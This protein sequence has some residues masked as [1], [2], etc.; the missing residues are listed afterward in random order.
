MIAPGTRLIK[1]LM[2]QVLRVVAGTVV[3]VGIVVL[4]APLPAAAGLMLTFPALN[5]L[6]FFFSEDARAAAMARSMLWMPVIN[7]VLCAGYIL[8]FAAVARTGAAVPA[9]WCLLVV[10]ILAWYAGV[11]RRQVQAGIAR[12][13]QLAYALVVT[14]AGL[15]LV[16]VAGA[17]STRLASGLMALPAATGAGDAG[18]IAETIWRSRLKIGL[19]AVALAVFLPAIAYLPISDSTRGILTGLP[20]VPFGG[21]VAIAGDAGIS[22]DARLAIIAGMLR[23]VWLAPAVAVWFILGFSR[24]LEARTKRPSPAADTAIR[25]GALVAGWLAAFAVIVVAGYGI[26]TLAAGSSKC[27]YPTTPN[28]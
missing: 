12:E 6:G 4:A 27:S 22:A 10:V 24:F 9:A 20:I 18:W 23:G 7:G 19:F 11:S 13:R 26:E 21:L 8:A 16:V 14:L 17:A 5:G 1:E 25:C 28:R 3:Y 15:V 2:R